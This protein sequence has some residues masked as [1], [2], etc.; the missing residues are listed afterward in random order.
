M[1]MGLTN[2]PGPLLA[3]IMGVTRQTLHPLVKSLEAQDA[4]EWRYGQIRILDPI[5]LG[6]DGS[7]RSKPAE[8]R[9]G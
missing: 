8:G 9:A 5:R 4:I 2:A 3:A 1:N 6:V 7:V